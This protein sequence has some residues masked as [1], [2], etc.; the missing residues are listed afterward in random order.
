MHIEAMGFREFLT[1]H[2]QDILLQKLDDW[3]F[4]RTFSSVLHE[5]A[6]Q[7]FHRYL[8]VGGMPEVVQSDVDHDDHKLCRDLQMDLLA[9]YRADFSKYSKRI[10]AAVL[11]MTLQAIS[12]SL[13]QALLASAG[14]VVEPACQ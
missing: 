13:Y 12:R 8:M 5:Q 2:Q 7:W 9:T 10:P 4:G 3:E 14:L 6:S 1:A 11:D